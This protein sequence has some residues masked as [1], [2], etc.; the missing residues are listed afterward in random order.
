MNTHQLDRRAV[1]IGGGITGLSAGWYL[2]QEAAR[3]GIN[4]SYTIL[5][6]SY[7]WGGKVQTEQVDET[8]DTPFILE[9]GP[10]AFLTRKP[11]ALE[12]ARELGLD[13]R[14][15]PVNM[16]NNHT[17][18]LHRGQPVPL[19]D[20]LQ[21]LAPTRLMPFLRSPLFSP[22]GKL[23]AMLD[24]FI[25][26]RRSD[27]DETL[28]N[29]VRRR[30]GAEML[31]TL[32]EPLLGGVFNGDP[33]RQS[34][35]ATF[36]NFP[37]LEKKYGSLIRGL[38]AGQRERT[39]P[40]FISF[41]SGTHELVDALVQRL[42]GDLRLN[43]GVSAIEHDTHYR[44]VTTDGSV[45][46]ADAL[47]LATPANVTAKLLRQIAPEAANH[48]DSIPYAGIGA[49]YF[50]FRREDIPRPLKG[51]GLVVPGSEGRQFDG[52]TW[53]SS[54]WTD[55]APDG[56]E[57]LRIFFGGPRTRHTL[58]MDDAELVRAMRG[59]LKS[60]FDISAAPLFYRIFRWQDGYPQYNIGHLEHVAAAEAAL[61]P[62][63]SL[64][65]SAYRGVGVPDCIRQG[66]DAAKKLAATFAENLQTA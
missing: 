4:L 23:R 17:F 16:E 63:I 5:E 24:F 55:R 62:G 59:E 57:L 7:R 47:I 46:E 50:A 13:E 45:I 25:P 14:I 33:E 44:V 18:V 21:L 51:F 41:K 65:G 10:D 56:F 58:H 42:N 37:A 8:G 30:L 60:I 40:A 28:A 32:G 11:W 36:P 49:I 31:D 20:G 27:A 53:T 64:A 9:A 3:Q 35:A 54:K 26:P 66:R 19:P 38:R 22:W 43:T 2:Q 52:I 12:L 15:L 34:M 61:S 39:V 48:L 29:F 1:I 6:S